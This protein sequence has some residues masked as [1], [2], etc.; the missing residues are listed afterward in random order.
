MGGYQIQPQTKGALSA[1]ARGIFLQKAM[2]LDELPDK[3]LYS[4]M[5]KRRKTWQA[6][7]DLHKV[8][9]M[10]ECTKGSQHYIQVF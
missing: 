5:E 6:E 10:Q 9:E 7:D 3:E 8:V 2:E 4:E 1:V